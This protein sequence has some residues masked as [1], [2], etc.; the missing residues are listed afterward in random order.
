MKS[1][2]IKILAKI[3]FLML[4]HCRFLFTELNR[5]KHAWNS[6]ETM[7]YFQH[8]T[9]CKYIEKLP[10][11]P[12]WVQQSRIDHRLKAENG[13]YQPTAFLL[14]GK[15]LHN[16]ILEKGQNL[17]IVFLINHERAVGLNI[18]RNDGCYVQGVKLLIIKI[19][20]EIDGFWIGSL[21]P[22][23]FL[24][25]FSVNR[26]VRISLWIRVVLKM[27]FIDLVDYSFEFYWII[28]RLSEIKLNNLSWNDANKAKIITQM[29]VEAPI[30]YFVCGCA[31]MNSLFII[32]MHY[33]P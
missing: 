24:P 3:G 15:F 29:F 8:E 16:R 4:K 32:I 14:F 28:L 25:N 18:H 26:C 6:H 21:S 17:D 12:Y 7:I 19:S 10:S 13:E 30:I 2:E 11:P 23:I 20:I 22:L 27:L 31:S 5:G 9:S 1:F 33:L